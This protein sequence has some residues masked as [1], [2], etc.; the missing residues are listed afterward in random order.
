MMQS[1]WLWRIWLLIQPSLARR[2]EKERS[3]PLKLRNGVWY[4]VSAENH[5]S[6]EHADAV[7]RTSWSKPRAEPSKRTRGEIAYMVVGFSGPY[8]LEVKYEYAADGRKIVFHV[9]R[10]GGKRRKSKKFKRD[11]ERKRR[12]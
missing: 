9:D 5:Y 4:T 6:W 11:Q 2:D 12:W 3:R 8:A 1:R 7:L 10:M